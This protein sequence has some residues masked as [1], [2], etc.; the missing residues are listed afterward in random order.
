MWF[1]ITFEVSATHAFFCCMQIFNTN[2]LHNFVFQF[3]QCVHFYSED[4]ILTNDDDLR[5]L[6]SFI[7]M[8][9]PVN[10]I[11]IPAI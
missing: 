10:V 5:S 9:I 4:F 8:Y 6:K 1:G 11:N 7:Y 2:K 3:M